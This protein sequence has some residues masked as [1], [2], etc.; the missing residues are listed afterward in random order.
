M[1]TNVL[2]AGNSAGN[3][4][5]GIQFESGSTQSRVLTNVTITGNRAETSRGGGIFKP[6]DLELRNSIIWN[7]SDSNGQ[8]HDLIDFRVLVELCE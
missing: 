5:G 2:I 8:G 6:G 1:L 3:S 4:G 7:N